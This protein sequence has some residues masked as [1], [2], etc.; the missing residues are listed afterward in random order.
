LSATSLNFKRYFSFDEDQLDHRPSHR[1][2]GTKLSEDDF[3]KLMGKSLQEPAGQL[4]SSQDNDRQF[5]PQVSLHESD[6]RSSS[7]ILVLC[8]GGTLTMA[9]DKDGSLAPV[10]GMLSKF[11]EQMEELR[12]P[13]MP[14]IVLH[15]YVWND[16]V[17]H[18]RNSHV[19]FF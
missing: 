1:S 8:T 2:R 13:G 11:M 7:R 5:I 4:W 18:T 10:E 16:F 15:E 14:D 6:G 12:Q 9:P 3:Q 19:F 17:A